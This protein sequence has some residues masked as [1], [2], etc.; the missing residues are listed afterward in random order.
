LQTAQ[1]ARLLGARIIMVGIQPEIAQSIVGLGLDLREIVTYPTLAAAIVS[2]MRIG[3]LK[4]SHP[5]RKV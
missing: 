4:A 3:K 1:A 5:D 2:L